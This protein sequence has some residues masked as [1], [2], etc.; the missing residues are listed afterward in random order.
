M[1]FMIFNKLLIAFCL[2]SSSSLKKRLLLE[3][4]YRQPDM[5]YYYVHVNYLFD[6]VEVYIS[7]AYLNIS[8]IIVG[9]RF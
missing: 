2:L 1:K 9:E 7:D 5:L 6:N 3:N 8:M 4:N